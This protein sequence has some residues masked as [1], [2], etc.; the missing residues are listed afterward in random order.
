M[1]GYRLGLKIGLGER[2]RCARSRGVVGLFDR[3]GWRCCI[4]GCSSTLRIPWRT[5]SRG[6]FL[7]QRLGQR[8]W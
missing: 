5:G 8:T 7:S 1:E 4:V 6:G 2:S 3:N